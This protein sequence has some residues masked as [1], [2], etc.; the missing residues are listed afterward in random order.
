MSP[1]VQSVQDMK[2]LLPELV[3]LTTFLVMFAADLFV[4]K[5]HTKWIAAA[6][7]AGLGAV[8]WSLLNQGI[9]LFHQEPVHLFSGMVTVD[10]FSIYFKWIFVTAT[11]FTLLMAVRSKEI[12]KQNEGEFYLLTVFICLG[13][14]FLASS[15]HLLMLLL[16]FEMVGVLSYV[17]AG[18]LR[19]DPRSS[20]SGMKYVIYGAFTTGVMIYGMSLLYGLTGSLELRGIRDALQGME[21]GAFPAVVILLLIAVGMF[22]KIAAAPFHMWSPDVY[23]GAPTPATAFFSVGPKA[24]GFAV[25]IRFF[26]TTLGYELPISWRQ[27]FMIL[28]IATMTIGNFTA[29]RQNDVKRMLAYSSIAHAGYLLMG[30]TVLSGDGRAAILFYLVVYMFMNLGA[31]LVVLGLENTLGST[32][33]SAYRGIGH[34]LPL[35]CVAMMI[36]L[37]SLTGLPPTA[38]FVGKFFLFKTVVEEGLYVLALIGVLNSVIS[39]Y[40]YMR[41]ARTMFL[42][43]PP[44]GDVTR[45]EFPPLYSALLVLLV[46][47][48]LYLGLFFQKLYELSSG[49]VF[50]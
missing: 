9:L 38:G 23:E 39:L 40:Y 5:R 15:T 3:L 35:P 20:E 50:E 26:L 25:L 44:A 30:L 14:F 24:A 43:T 33:I 42:E 29:L 37:F 22:Y 19:G 18:Y 21:A 4:Q 34:A 16:A 36:F 41:I 11:G 46:A 48:T 7:I 17:L 47:P 27:I 12:E 2:G 45:S 8:L 28:A 13:M 6:G 1:A 31:F 49:A 10:G 32:D